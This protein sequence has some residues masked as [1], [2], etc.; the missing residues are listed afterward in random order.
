MDQLFIEPKSDFDP[1]STFQDIRKRKLASTSMTNSHQN[2]N[3]FKLFQDLNLSQK[4]EINR[5]FVKNGFSNEI[6]NGLR[7][8]YQPLNKV[9]IDRF[10]KYSL[11]N[12]EN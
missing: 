12:K 10:D 3:I 4:Y 1:Y 9:K 11:F 8:R 6:V 2:E 5:K 7:D